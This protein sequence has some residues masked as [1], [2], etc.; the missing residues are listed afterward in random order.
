MYNITNIAKYWDFNN[1]EGNNAYVMEEDFGFKN[2]IH[3]L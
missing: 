3:R 2:K 1:I